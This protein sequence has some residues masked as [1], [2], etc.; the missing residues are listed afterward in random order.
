MIWF[1]D[2]DEKN[3]CLRD[4]STEQFDSLLVWCLFAIH[5]KTRLGGNEL[6]FARVKNFSLSFLQTTSFLQTFYKLYNSGS[7]LKTLFWLNLPPHR[8]SACQNVWCQ[9]VLNRLL[10]FDIKCDLLPRIALSLSLCKH[11]H[12]PN[13]TNVLETSLKSSRS[14]IVSHRVRKTHWKGTKQKLNKNTSS[15]HC[16]L[17]KAIDRN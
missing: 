15:F 7:F 14:K 11:I 3:R 4:F 9:Y 8:T 16:V 10:K 6:Y 12:S 2:C 13:D 5:R 17:E 1:S